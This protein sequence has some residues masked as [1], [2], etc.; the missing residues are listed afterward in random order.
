MET[1]HESSKYLWGDRSCGR[2][3]TQSA[4]LGV[5]YAA[6]L[7]ATATGVASG[8][9]PTIDPSQSRSRTSTD[10][11]MR[12]RFQQ[13]NN[14]CNSDARTQRH[15]W[16]HGLRKVGGAE[17][18]NFLTENWNFFQRRLRVLRSSILLLN[19]PKM[20][21]QPKFLFLAENFRLFWRG[22]LLVGC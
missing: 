7:S 9:G 14:G 3:C 21:F 12:K 6:W 5:K 4:R 13:L 1:V 11:G 20:N 2:H 10:Y 16:T 18:A 17:N 8:C 22:G 15:S 19:L